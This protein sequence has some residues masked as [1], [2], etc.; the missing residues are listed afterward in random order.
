MF[1]KKKSLSSSLMSALYR[2][3]SPLMKKEELD[4][5]ERIMKIGGGNTLEI[6]CGSGRLYLPLL[7]KGY[8]IDGVEESRDMLDLL[9]HKAQSFDLIP[10]VELFEAK[11]LKCKVKYT[12][13]FIALGSFQ[14]IKSKKCAQKLLKQIYNNLKDSGKVYISLFCPEVTQLLYSHDWAIV[15]DYYHA[16]EKKRF[17]RREKVNVDL[18]EQHLDCIV[19]YETWID[20]DLESMFEKRVVLNWYS[21]D[22]FI[23][24]LED[25]GFKD[26]R[27]CRNYGNNTKNYSGFMLFQGEK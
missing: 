12:T 20:K 15:N 14:M 11:N 23:Y 10:K 25:L 2:Y 13:I 7:Q 27:C 26:I 5:Y 6:A 21:K 22:E 19:R 16:E 17:V 8:L 24:I 1:K 3:W 9:R 4:F 18:V